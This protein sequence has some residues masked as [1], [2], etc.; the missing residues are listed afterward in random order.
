M[1]HGRF[2]DI[3]VMF[4]GNNTISW[5]KMFHVKL[6]LVSI[7]Q[8]MDNVSRETILLP[9]QCSKQLDDIISNCKYCCLRS[10]RYIN[11]FKNIG[12]M[13]FD[14]TLADI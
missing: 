13:I 10:V 11:L 12:N 2:F 8:I 3:F 9:A 1:F 5:V 6:Y 14:S 4:H 7:L